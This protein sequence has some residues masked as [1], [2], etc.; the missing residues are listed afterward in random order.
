MAATFSF[1]I[2]AAF[3]HELC[4]SVTDFRHLFKRSDAGGKDC[5]VTPNY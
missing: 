2:I 3:A 5:S 4:E 1:L